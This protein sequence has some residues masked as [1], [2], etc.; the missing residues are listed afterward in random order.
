MKN[1]IEKTIK[2]TMADIIKNESIHAAITSKFEHINITD[3]LMDIISDNIINAD[4]D[5]EFDNLLEKSM[6]IARNV[7]AQIVTE[8]KNIQSV[9]NASVNSLLAI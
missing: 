8:L 2:T 9:M 5:K 1:E 3:S 6:N 7:F 4:D